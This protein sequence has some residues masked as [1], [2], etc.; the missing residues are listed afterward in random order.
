MLRN[1][2]VLCEMLT[3][4]GTWREGVASRVKCYVVVLPEL[5]FFCEFTKVCLRNLTSDR[6]HDAC[7]T[8][9][10]P[11]FFFSE[12]LKYKQNIQPA[13]DRFTPK[14]LA[15][16]S[17]NCTRFMGLILRMKTALGLWG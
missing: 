2:S 3:Q 5:F 11:T 15:A 17:E 7:S 9:E 10:Q 13:G 6:S 16:E 1:R 14:D 8:I 4:I 12:P